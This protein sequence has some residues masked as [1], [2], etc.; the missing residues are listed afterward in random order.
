MAINDQQRSEVAAFLRD[1]PEASALGQA[2][3]AL[4]EKLQARFPHLQSEEE[5]TMGDLGEVIN[6][7]L[8]WWVWGN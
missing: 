1:A 6:A 2:Y 7:F 4:A 3:D 5:Y 8:Y